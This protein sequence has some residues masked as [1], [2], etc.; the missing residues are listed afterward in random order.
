MIWELAHVL[1]VRFPK[2]IYI[3]LEQGKTSNIGN[4]SVVKIMLSDENW[5]QRCKLIYEQGYGI[6]STAVEALL[7][8]ASLVPTEVRSEHMYNGSK[9]SNDVIECILGDL[10]AST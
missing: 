6:K 3:S 7:K 1:A 10:G 4:E 9:C 2:S 8:V 5:S